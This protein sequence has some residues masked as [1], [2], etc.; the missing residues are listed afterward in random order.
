MYDRVASSP[1]S[2]PPSQRYGLD[3]ALAQKSPPKKGPNA[4]VLRALPPVFCLL[5]LLASPG[6][7]SPLSPVSLAYPHRLP[8]SPPRPLA[9][10]SQG[11]FCGWRTLPERRFLSVL[12]AF[13][14]LLSG[15]SD[16]SC[17]FATGLLPFR[18]LFPPICDGIL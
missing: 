2:F 16:R 9:P 6:P 1:S 8:F 17:R 10:F 3:R 14:R 5:S 12:V 18:S 7:L 4:S 15:F 11:L 13:S